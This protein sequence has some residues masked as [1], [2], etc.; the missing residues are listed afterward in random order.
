MPNMAGFFRISGSTCQTNKNY[1]RSPSTKYSCHMHPSLP[2][3][4]KH[5]N[6]SRRSALL[7]FSSLVITPTII[8]SPNT[9]Q[10]AEGEPQ[11]SSSSSSLPKPYIKTCRGLITSLRDSI[12]ADL[13]GLDEREV[14]RKAD[15]AKPFVRDFM[16]NWQD[17]PLVVDTDSHR[18]LLST[19]KALG[20]FYASRGQRARLDSELGQR[21]LDSLDAAEAALPVVE[22]NSKLPFPF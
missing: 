7:S 14:R 15:P 8:S 2:K 10:A 6:L 13:T 4:P 18:E 21:L 5:H 11:S 17:T 19:I 16:S 9:A 12:S 22:E 20:T 1:V 3:D